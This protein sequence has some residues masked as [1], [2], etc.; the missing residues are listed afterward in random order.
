[1][2][3]TDIKPFFSATLSKIRS[4][5]FN[6]FSFA[7][8]FLAERITNIFEFSQNQSRYI[9]QY[10]S[11]MDES[12]SGV[13]KNMIQGWC[14]PSAFFLS[15]LC[16]SSKLTFERIPISCSPSFISS[17]S[18][19]CPS[20]SSLV[21]SRWLSSFRTVTRPSLFSASVIYQQSQ[22]KNFLNDQLDAFHNKLRNEIQN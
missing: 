16:W 1:M 22:T 7:V 10:T 12:L 8:S 11:G 3:N 13:L 17:S 19:C 5:S 6:I 20:D 15:S 9:I 4:S 14:I 21:L 2:L 18:S